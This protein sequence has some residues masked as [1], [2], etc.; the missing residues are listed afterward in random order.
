NVYWNSSFKEHLCRFLNTYAGSANT[1]SKPSC[2][3]R[4]KPNVQ[5]VTGKNSLRSSRSLL[6]RGRARHLSRLIH[7]IFHLVLAALAEPAAIPAV[8]A[9][10]H[11][12]TWTDPP[13]SSSFPASCPMTYGTC[14]G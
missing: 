2:L 8:Q 6:S 1:S 12:R 11:Y 7:L 9:P 3:A 13:L 5:S 10:V 14:C 4:T